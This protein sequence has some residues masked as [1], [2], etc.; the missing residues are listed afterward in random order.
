MPDSLKEDTNVYCF[1]SY[2]DRNRIDSFIIPEK[3]CSFFFFAFV[4]EQLESS[5]CI[6][7]IAKALKDDAGRY[8]CIATNAAGEAQQSIYLHVYG[9]DFSLAFSIAC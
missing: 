7:Q 1:C 3:S 4:L 2:Y 5:G 9:N 8:T 6:L